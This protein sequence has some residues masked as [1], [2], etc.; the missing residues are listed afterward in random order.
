MQDFSLDF[1]YMI[2]LI[3]GNKFCLIKNSFIYCWDFY[4][5]YFLTFKMIFGMDNFST[6][7]MNE[8]MIF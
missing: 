2:L 7:R 8:S 5:K 4:K 3:I 6:K 1:I